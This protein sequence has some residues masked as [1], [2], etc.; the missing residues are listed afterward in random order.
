MPI[1]MNLKNRNVCVN[2]FRGGRKLSPFP[3]SLPADDTFSTTRD[4]NSMTKRGAE[5]ENPE[6]SVERAR[7]YG[8]SG[9]VLEVY[10]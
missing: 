2:W 9:G 10:R 6:V 8:G 4:G 5:A 1:E 7:S 3:H